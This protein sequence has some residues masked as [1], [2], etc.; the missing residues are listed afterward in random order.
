MFLFFAH[1][2]LSRLVPFSFHTLDLFKAPEVGMGDGTGVFRTA[3]ALMSRSSVC[4]DR[5]VLFVVAVDSDCP[6]T[7]KAME[8]QQTPSIVCFTSYVVC[9]AKTF[10]CVL[11]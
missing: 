4:I 3:M 11:V 6:S 10:S 7:T 5:F 2:T 8:A 1:K 9:C